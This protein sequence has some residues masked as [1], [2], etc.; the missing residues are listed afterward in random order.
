MTTIDYQVQ[1]G[2]GYV[3]LNRPS[4]LNAYNVAMRDELYQVLSAVKE[5]DEVAVL[6]LRGRGRAFC[7]GADLTEFGTAPSQA[8]A[9][10]V[11]WQRDIW[12]SFLELGK[13]VV[14]AIHG[15]CIGS[16]LEMALLCDLRL[17]TADAVF[18]MPE[19]Q[20]GMIPAA[21]GTQT[22]PR[23]LGLSASL[24]LL[25]TGRRIDAQEA[26]ATGLVGRVFPTR[27]EMDA[28][29]EMLARYLASISVAASAAKRAVREGADLPLK[30]ALDLELKLA[31]Q[32]V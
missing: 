15:Y 10:Q 16:G 20:L 9:R 17:A 32:L 19:A 30:A 11:R 13:P 22:L 27:D 8:I 14:C 31:A 3:W 29:V 24:E 4:V 25:L 1:E 18:A 2:V 7:A 21:G 28:E 12:G 5:D 6:V 26:L 23:T